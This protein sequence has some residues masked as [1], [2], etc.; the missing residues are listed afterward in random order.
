MLR[1]GSQFKRALIF[2]HRWMGVALCLLFFLWFSSGIAMMYWEYPLVSREDRLAHAAVL[3]AAR[4]RLSPSEAYA[5]LGANTPPPVEVHLAI[6]DGRPAYKFGERADQLIV[7]ADTGETQTEFPSEMTRRIAAAWT[8]QPA[9]SAKEEENVPV[10]QW[11]VSEEFAEL[12]PLRKYT[13]PDGEQVYVS[14]QTGEVAQ[15]TTRV[16]RL[17]AYL[18]PIPHWLYFTPL[19]RHG[20]RWSA[21]VIWASGLATA[22]GIIGIAL[23]VSMYSPSKPFRYQGAPSALPYVGWKR[24]HA[25]L[26][27]IFG[28]LACTWA[29]SG[30][31]SMDP[32]PAWQGERRNTIG[33]RFEQVIGAQSIDLVGFAAKLPPEAVAEA[34]GG[35]KEMDLTSFIGSPVYLAHI[36]PNQT[37]VVPAHGQAS[38]EF[39]AEEIRGALEKA[40]LPHMVSQFRAVTRYEAYYLDRRNRLPLPAIFA[41]LNDPDRSSLYIDPKTARVVESYNQRSRR[42]RWLY[43]GLHSI[44]LPALYAHRPAWDI[45]VLILMLGGASLSITSL[46]LAWNVL[47]RKLQSSGRPPAP[48]EKTVPAAP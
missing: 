16:A 38:D 27:L 29:F 7:Y 35:V 17:G 37:R 19:R 5:R 13:W 46:I 47:Q 2:V 8:G 6:F 21:M 32:F 23:G 45:V 14:T 20:A 30:M 22:L 26:G 33:A 42:N 31:L 48:A 28:V 25:I 15:Y 24:W 18:G 10:D 43:H 36:G 1:L 11:T 9:I 4:I 12:R 41:Q 40:A 34:G 3:D 44:D 39:D